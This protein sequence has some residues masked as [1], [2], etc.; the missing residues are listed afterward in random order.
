MKTLPST[1]ENLRTFL[2]EARLYIRYGQLK[3]DDVMSVVKSSGI[4]LS[5]EFI[6]VLKYFVD[7]SNNPLGLQT[8]PRALLRKFYT[9]IFIL[10]KIDFFT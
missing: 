2:K 4:L 3:Y 1:P 8:K 7:P 10:C 5:S 6:Q 9:Y